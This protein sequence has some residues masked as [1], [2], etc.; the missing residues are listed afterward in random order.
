MS[1]TGEKKEEIVE[2]ITDVESFD[3]TNGLFRKTYGSAAM[4]DA[5]ART[6]KMKEDIRKNPRQPSRGFVNQGLKVMTD[7]RLSEFAK[8]QLYEGDWSTSSLNL[9]EDWYR[10]CKESA[11]AHAEAARKARQKH[12]LLTIPTILAGTAATALAFFSAG[13]SCDADED[14]SNGLKYS[15][16]FFTSI[17]SVLGG[18]QTLYSFDRKVAQCINASGNFENLARQAQIQIFLPLKLRA[19]SELVLTEISTIFA[20]LTTSSP[21]L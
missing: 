5:E 18:I 4:D 12:R 2:T 6:T 15:T 17:V 21:L 3:I 1:S 11:T 16:A 9:L 20:H 14:N 7:A 8:E 13:E 19:H 10:A